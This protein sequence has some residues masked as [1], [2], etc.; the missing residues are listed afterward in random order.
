MP[1]AESEYDVLRSSTKKK[2]VSLPSAAMRLSGV[3]PKSDKSAG[4]NLATEWHRTILGRL[5]IIGMR[6]LESDDSDNFAMSYEQLYFRD[7]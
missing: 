1:E 2:C 5:S 6:L 3:A 7:V 4:F